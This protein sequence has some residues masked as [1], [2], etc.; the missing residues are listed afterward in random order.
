MC[1]ARGPWGHVPPIEMPPMIKH[2]KKAI[3]SLVSF[4]IIA[5]KSNYRLTITLMTRVP[6]STEFFYTNEL[7][8]IDWVKF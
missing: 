4:S 5:Y 1:E 8:C 2:D 6:G 3:V 7:K